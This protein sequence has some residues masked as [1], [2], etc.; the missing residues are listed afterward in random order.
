[1][2]VYV[3]ETGELEDF[4]PGGSKYFGIAAAFTPDLSELSSLDALRF[5]LHAEGYSFEG[6][7][8][9]AKNDPTPRRYRVCET[10]GKMQRLRVHSVLLPKQRI[11]GPLWGKSARIFGIATETLFHYLFRHTVWLNHDCHLVFAAYG[12]GKVKQQVRQE[13]TDAVNRAIKRASHNFKVHIHHCQAGSERGLQVADYCA[14]VIQ[15]QL[16]KGDK[17]GQ[18]CAQHLGATLN[19]P[20]IMFGG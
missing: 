3:D 13:Q 15:R 9:H 20:F 2:Y 10:I 8:F 5:D 7:V 14:W 17:V 18:Q 16:E 6:G 4:S 12:A 11:Y 1:M 19:Q